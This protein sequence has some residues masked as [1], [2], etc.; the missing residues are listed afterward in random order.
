MVKKMERPLGKVQLKVL[1]YLAENPN[2]LIKP[3][4][5][6]ISKDY[7]S[8]Y[9]AVKTLK[10]KGYVT[11]ASVKANNK[12]VGFP[13]YRLTEKGVAYLMR[14]GKP[15]ISMKAFESYFKESPLFEMY[16]QLKTLV[17]QKIIIK[18][19]KAAGEGTVKYGKAVWQ[20][21][22]LSKILLIFTSSLTPKESLQLKKATKKI[23]A[24]RKLIREAAYAVYKEFSEEKESS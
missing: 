24:F 5:R 21:N 11:D 23:P 10:A 13:S 17:N 16:S 3:I 9:G 4:S 19:L 15:E 1:E 20:I 18:L 12:G 22:N 14:Y 2:S 6:A 7:K 8:T